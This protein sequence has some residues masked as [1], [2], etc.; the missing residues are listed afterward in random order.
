MSIRRKTLATLACLGVMGAAACGSD[1]SAGSSEKVEITVAGYSGVFK[2][3]YTKAVIDPFLAK[4]S[5]VTVKYREFTGSADHL[6]AVRTEKGR[7]SI[8]VSIIDF[9]SSFVA[10][11]EGLYQPLDA[12][13]VPNMKDV[14]AQG[15]VPGGFGPAVTF[16]N[17]ELM[18]NKKAFPTPP[19]SWTDLAKAEYK[20]KVVVHSAHTLFL[21]LSLNHMAGGDYKNS[22]DP[23]VNEMKKIAPLV[24]TWSPKPDAYTP[25][26]NGT[27]V[28]GTAHNARAQ[29][30]IDKSQGA[31]GVVIP[32]EGVV[33]Q[34]N[35]INLVKGS[36][37]AKAAQQFIDYAL[38]P[39][40][41]ESFADAM[42]YQPTNTKV[43]LRPET[44]A[45]TAAGMATADQ[46]LEVDW[47]YVAERNS[48]WNERIHREVIGG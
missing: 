45:R 43:N 33:V 4:N 27:A 30:Y 8:D 25:V 24:Q 35:T 44:K 16:D 40:A 21:A 42:F 15:Q 46:L 14:A 41:Q 6:A 19:T 29:L 2:E 47:S 12:A 22:I 48:A 3:Q 26:A 39:A 20:G 36:K 38:S 32:K 11:K 31:I 7:P 37:Q 34:V 17:L 18:Y 1:D 5:G 23:G 13:L 10:N 9:N 28:I